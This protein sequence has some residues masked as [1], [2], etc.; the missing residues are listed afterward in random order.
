MAAP[1]LL[2]VKMASF[3]LTAIARESADDPGA[4]RVVAPSGR[5]QIDARTFTITADD[6]KSLVHMPL[7]FC[8]FGAAIDKILVVP[9]SRAPAWMLRMSASDS[10][11]A[12]IALMSAGCVLG[13]ADD[14]N[15]PDLAPPRD[16]D[17]VAAASKPGFAALVAK[18]EANPELVAQIEAALARH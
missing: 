12:Q 2:K 14:S 9:A 6:D 10:N 11:A 18:M 1:S 4:Y 13:H 7:S 5:F 17:L 3:A 8:L 15:A 16:D